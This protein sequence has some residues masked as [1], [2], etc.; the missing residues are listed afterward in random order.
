MMKRLDRYI[1]TEFVKLLL[2][3]T[4]GFITIFILV[5][6]FE[7]MDNLVKFHV[8][9]SSSLLFFIYKIPFIF[10]QVTPVAVLLSVLLSV[11]MLSISGEMTAVRASGV[12]LLRVFIPIMI[13]GFFI[14]LSVIFINEYL[15]PL[16]LKKTEAFKVQWFGKSSKGSFGG[17]GL[18]FRTKDSII[19]IRHVRPG[20]ERIE[21]V[22]I[23]KIE[24]PFRL[25]R[26][27]DAKK[28]RWTGDKWMVEGAILRDFKGDGRVT[29]RRAGPLALTNIAP[30]EELGAPDN[31]HMSLT[32]EEL[33]RLIRILDAEGY[34]THQYRTDLYS[35][36]AFPFISFIMVL[37]GIPF[38]LRGARSGGIASGIGLCIIIAF[39]YWIVFALST[40]LGSGGVLPPIVAA[41]FPD[42]L[43]LAI[44]SYLLAHVKE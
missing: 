17:N 32:M 38:P 37:L 12:R 22:T 25:V 36:V 31:G 41:I 9:M 26:R 40:S 16:G 24:K 39:S 35:R 34:E 44:A 30:P 11:G 10:G 18:W 15:T 1:F 29:R 4:A 6:L 42:L 7:N 43:F 20:E 8:P 14:S 21:G 2:L 13:A 28:A 27:I 3:T 19:N 23:Y 5:D 33:K